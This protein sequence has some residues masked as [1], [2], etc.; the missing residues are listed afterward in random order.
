[1]H[2]NMYHKT[3]V[4]LGSGCC[5]IYN[6]YERERERESVTISPTVRRPMMCLGV[7]G[8]SREMLR[9][10]LYAA[11]NGHGK[12]TAALAAQALLSSV[13]V[14]SM[15]CIAHVRAI[16]VVPYELVNPNSTDHTTHLAVNICVYSCVYV[17][18]SK[19]SQAPRRMCKCVDKRGC[20]VVCSTP[21][22]SV[23]S[24]HRLTVPL[25]P[26]SQRVLACSND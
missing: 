9:K 3:C 11:E 12:P 2:V 1:M 18:Q 7:Q 10:W 8:N 19:D 17:T 23:E 26:V 21:P 14:A 22:T 6:I 13:V 15:F 25:R 24:R 4:R 16:Y 20:F 5:S